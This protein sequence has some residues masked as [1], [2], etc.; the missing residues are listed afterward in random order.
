MINQSN[1]IC[2]ALTYAYRDILIW[3]KEKNLSP[4]EE[5]LLN[6]LKLNL[7]LCLPLQ[8][9]AT[10]KLQDFKRIEDPTYNQKKF[11]EEGK[12]YIKE[13]LEE[14]DNLPNYEHTS[15]K[16][17]SFFQEPNNEYKRY[18]IIKYYLEAYKIAKILGIDLNR[19]K[20]CCHMAYRICLKLDEYKKKYPF[21]GDKG[22]WE[23]DK[24]M[25]KII[26]AVDKFKKINKNHVERK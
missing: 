18:E 13:F 17:E 25:N 3:E 24:K 7:Q 10:S 1:N 14:I 26:E 19:L 20:N 15:I 21:D 9:Y 23:K 6:N 16:K 11:F 5:K 4:Y 12:D 2:V 8:K 22:L